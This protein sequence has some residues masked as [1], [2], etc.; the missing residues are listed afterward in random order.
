M[1][2]QERRTARTHG[3]VRRENLRSAGRDRRRES[4]QGLPRLSRRQEAYGVLGRQTD[5]RQALQGS[6]LRR[7]DRVL[8]L[9]RQR[10][11]PSGARRKRLRR[12]NCDRPRDAILTKDFESWVHFFV[13]PHRWDNVRTGLITT[14]IHGQPT[15]AVST[16]KSP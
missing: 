3:V 16:I 1:E 8:G 15:F 4:A 6:R 2:G 14:T 11:R 12:D 10:E 5:G 9:K 13:Q 7:Q